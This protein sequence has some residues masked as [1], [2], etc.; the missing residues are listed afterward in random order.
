MKLCKQT[1]VLPVGSAGKSPRVV[2]KQCAS[3]AGL[4]TTEL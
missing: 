1:E 4:F 3:L 2:I